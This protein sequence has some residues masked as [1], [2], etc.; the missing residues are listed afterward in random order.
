MPFV[1]RQLAALSTA[2]ILF[3]SSGSDALAQKKYDTGA[4]DAEIK[5]GKFM[6]YSGPASAY[7][8]IGRTMSAY[9]RM[10]NDNGGING[11]KINF[12]S[13]DDGYSPPKTVEQAR[14]LVESDEV[15]LIFASLGTATNAAIQ[16]YMNAMRVP[17]I[18]V[19]TGASR[20]GDPEHFPWTIG[21]QPTYRAEARIYASYILTNHPNAKVGVLYQNDDFG[22]DYIQG[23]KDGLGDKFDKTVI[24]SA[25]YDVGTPTVDS[26][27]VAIRT[28]KPDVF[29]NIATPKYAA[30]AIRKVAE[31]DWHPIHIMTN[32]SNSIGGVIKPAG[33]KNAEGIL[34]ALYNMDVTDPQWDSYP[35]MQR[36]RAFLAKYYPEADK[37]DAGTIAAYNLSTGLVEVLKE[38]GDNLTRENVM[39]VAANL[40]FEVETLRPGIRVKTSPTDFYPIEQMRMSRFNGEHWEGFGPVIDS[41][42]DQVALSTK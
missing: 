8:I 33:V 13:Y 29:I 12:I 27:V 35:G 16:K 34:T 32:V 38:C 2:I 3:A 37:S 4:T 41:H 7:G 20:F 10:I 15:F 36:F 22:K 17:Q 30:Q 5:I 39:K 21:W 11:R 19:S 28:A 9:F 24:V 40:D 42:I 23:L 26:E 1:T 25:P 18:F 31:L 6:P 14:K